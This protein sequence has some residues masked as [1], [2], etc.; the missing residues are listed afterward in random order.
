MDMSA[1]YQSQHGTN[2][3][4]ILKYLIPASYAGVTKVEF[5]VDSVLKS[6]D[7]SSPYSFSWDTT[8][9][10]NGAHSLMA[11]AF[12]AAGN[13]GS[14]AA[15]SVTV[16][17]PAPPP[18]SDTIAPTV[19]ITSPS[20][21]STVSKKLK[22]KAS[23]SDNVGVKKVEFYVDGMLKKTDSSSP[24]SV[25]LNTK[26][27]ANSSHV[28]MAK[29]YDAAGNVGSASVTFTSENK[30]K[31]QKFSTKLKGANE[32]PSVTTKAKGKGEFEVDTSKNELKFK[33]EFEKLSSEEASAHI[34][35]PA[36]AGENAGVLFTL[37]AGK[38]KKGVW[39]YPESVENDLLKGSLY[40]NVHSSNY[41][42]GEIRGQIVP[43]A[44][45]ANNDDNEDDDEDDDD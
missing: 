12:D 6:T 42:N 27:L 11:K 25:K 37:P 21:G 14:S 9:S 15:V 3:N 8:M 5:Y 28:L 41:P 18:P 36:K 23:A 19:S 16:N 10:P 45:S 29:A 39:N 22:V 1:V 13:A 32:V 44:K 31:K 2:V 34:H 38:E 24:Y 7:T 43:K 35:G 30:V 26:K 33:I 17:N 4:R 40:V 20:A